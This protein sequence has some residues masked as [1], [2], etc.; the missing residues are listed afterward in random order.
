MIDDNQWEPDETFD[1]VLS[2]PE[3]QPDGSKGIF[4]SEPSVSTI[5]IINDDEPGVLEFAEHRYQVAESEGELVVTVKRKN[6]SD[7]TVTCK[8]NTQDHQTEAMSVLNLP[9]SPPPMLFL[10]LSKY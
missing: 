9:K 4:L 2:D 5:T 8:Y 10:N 6:G 3:K 7:G 1:I